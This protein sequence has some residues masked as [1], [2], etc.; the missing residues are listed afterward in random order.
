MRTPQSKKTKEK[1]QKKK[2]SILRAGSASSVSQRTT[3]LYDI[4]QDLVQNIEQQQQ[5]LML[6]K[7]KQDK[8]LEVI[9]K[10]QIVILL[11]YNSI[12][13]KIGRSYN[14]KTY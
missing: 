5:L 2:F 3:S 4:S 12:F 13:I 10:N 7:E 1:K 14:C 11:H 9:I 6:I 8:L